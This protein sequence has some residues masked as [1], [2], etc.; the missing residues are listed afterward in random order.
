MWIPFLTLETALKNVPDIPKSNK[1]KNKRVPSY[2]VRTPYLRSS[3]S[4]E[5]VDEPQPATVTVLVLSSTTLWL[6]GGQP[7]QIGTA[8]E[9]AGSSLK[10]FKKIFWGLKISNFWGSKGSFCNNSY[11]IYAHTPK[12]IESRPFHPWALLWPEKAPLQG[13]LPYY[14]GLKLDHLNET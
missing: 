10:S 11:D 2:L 12:I 3:W 6:F 9:L 7:K 8:I 4:G 13:H 1:I 5:R 14:Q